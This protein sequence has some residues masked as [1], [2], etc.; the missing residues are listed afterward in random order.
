MTIFK[1]I[2]I[3]L[4]FCYSVSS[5]GQHTFVQFPDSLNTSTKYYSPS[6]KPIAKPAFWG[7]LTI[8]QPL[9]SLDLDPYYKLR[10]QYKVDDAIK[11]KYSKNNGLSIVLDTVQEVNCTE[12][13]FYSKKNRKYYPANKVFFT[14]GDET[15]SVKA[16]A[17]KEISFKGIPVCIA[18]LSDTEI[19]VKHPKYR[20]NII[21]EAL[22]KDNEWK[23]IESLFKAPKSASSSLTVHT[24]KPGQFI[25]TAVYKYKGDFQTQLRLKLISGNKVYYSNPYHGTINYLQISN[26]KNFELN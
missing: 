18:N 2:F 13:I 4:P 5:F 6:F 25:L 22:D 10:P 20:I 21:Q 14:E 23:P 7:I 12:Y 17:I 11:N 8:G 24:L 1:L 19:A 3:L 26:T 16:T 15:K 9:D